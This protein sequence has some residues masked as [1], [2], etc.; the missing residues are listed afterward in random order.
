MPQRK[1]KITIDFD[2]KFYD[3]LAIKNTIQAYEGLAKFNLKINKKS[4]KLEA[5]DTDKDIKDVFEDEFC[6]YVLS[7]TKKVKSLCL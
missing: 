2:K 3:R 1:N 6:N 4:F 7:E 5:A